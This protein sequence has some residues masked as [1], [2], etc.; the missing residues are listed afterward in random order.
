MPE[1]QDRCC[2]PVFQEALNAGQPI[3]LA[4][5]GAHEVALRTLSDEPVEIAFW[6]ELAA[7]YGHA[8]AQDLLKMPRLDFTELRRRRDEWLNRTF[9]IAPGTR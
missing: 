9:K 8:P 6:L 7:H 3:A 4:A 2:S 1:M 5:Y